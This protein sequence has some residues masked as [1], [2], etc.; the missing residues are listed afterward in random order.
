MYSLSTHRCSCINHSAK[1]LDSVQQQISLF[2]GGLREG[3]GEGT[4]HD[5]H[6][7]IMN[8]YLIL[9]VLAVWPGGND[10]TPHLIYLTVETA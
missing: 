6:M 3:W 4:A 1:L 9:E 10:H 5:S 2:N 8:A 7:T